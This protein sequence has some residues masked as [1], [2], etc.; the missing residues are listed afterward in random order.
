MVSNEAEAPN[1][2]RSTIYEIVGFRVQLVKFFVVKEEI[3]SSISTYT[4]KPI[5][6]LV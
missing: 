4:K 5:G 1:Q 6:L 3:W 2:Q